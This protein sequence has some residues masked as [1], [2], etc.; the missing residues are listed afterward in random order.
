MELR[1]FFINIEITVNVS[2]K[3]ISNEEIRKQVIRFL[4]GGMDRR[5]TNTGDFYIQ[6][7][8][9]TSIMDEKGKNINK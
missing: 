2:K 5:K 3:D 6:D 7:D 1:K 8:K 4:D 9:I